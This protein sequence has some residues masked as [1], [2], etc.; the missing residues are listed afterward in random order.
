MIGEY[1]S[2]E[3]P[4]I[5]FK[6]KKVLNPH[7]ISH[8]ASYRDIF[9]LPKNKEESFLEDFLDAKKKNQKKKKKKKKLF[10]KFRRNKNNEENLP[11]TSEKENLEVKNSI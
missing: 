9:P 1:H 6:N 8:Y 3:N 5:D 10:S 11:L 2:N 7:S 4:N